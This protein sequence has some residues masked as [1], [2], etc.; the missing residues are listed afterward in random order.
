M[1]EKMVQRMKDEQNKSMYVKYCQV[2][3]FNSSCSLFPSTSIIW[4]TVVLNMNVDIRT[5]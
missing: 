5:H 3:R 2:E 4:L 1:W